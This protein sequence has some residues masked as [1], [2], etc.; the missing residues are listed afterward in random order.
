MAA[1][2]KLL[3]VT[4]GDNLLLD[5]DITDVLLLE[6]A[7]ASTLNQKRISAMHF[8]KPYQPTAMAEDP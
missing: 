4:G 5:S 1:G 2:D 6:E 3:L 7:P 8:L